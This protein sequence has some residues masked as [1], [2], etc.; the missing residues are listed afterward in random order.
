MG[1]FKI[2]TI[3]PFLSLGL[4]VSCVKDPQDIPGSSNGDEIFGIQGT[5]GNENVSIGAGLN[6]WTN[7]PATVQS[8]SIDSYTSLFSLNGCLQQCAPSWRFDFYQALPGLDDPAADFQQTIQ[9][10]PK[11]YVTSEE[12]RRSYDILLSTHPGLFMSGYSF[13][14][15]LNGSPSSFFHEYQSTAG[16]GDTVNVCFQ[17]FAYTGCMYKQCVSF[18]PVTEVPCLVRID[19]KLENPRY[20][21]LSVKPSGT[22]PF[23]VQWSNGATTL[24]RVIPLQD[25]VSEVYA[26]VTVTDA[27]GNQSTLSQTIRIQNLAV[28]ACYFPIELT[29]NPHV[30]ENPDAYKNRVV[31]T[32][33]DE[34]GDTWSSL[35][36]VQPETSTL[37]IDGIHYYGPSPGGETAYVVDVTAVVLLTNSVTGESRTFQTEQLS[38]ALSHR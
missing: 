7:L 8:D 10:G 12:E 6:Q 19:A 34:N 22:A 33:V 14:A 2:T 37:T 35:G 29:S 13:W 28:D 17:S 23:Q 25:S 31:V 18:N 15:D 5:L 36:K 1:A 20:L 38:L 32:Y 4:L 27:L 30:N 16:Y 3:L 21:N 11:K 24:N 26:Q 9:V